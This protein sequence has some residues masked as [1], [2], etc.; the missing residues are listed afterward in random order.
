MVAPKADHRR[1][2]SLVRLLNELAEAHEQL[3]GAVEEKIEAMRSADTD[4]IRQT[5]E[6]EQ[7][8]VE[9]IDEREGLRRQ[10]TESIVR[11]YGLGAVAARRLSA[12]QLAKRLGAPHAETILAAGRRLQELTARIARRNHVAQLISQNILRHMK[13]VFAAMTVARSGAVGYS[14]EGEAF[15]VGAEKIFDAVG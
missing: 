11:A 8:L 12:R 15:V 5:I 10:L 9:C 13:H 7:T 1:V 2:D 4:R 6:R 14:P 3:L